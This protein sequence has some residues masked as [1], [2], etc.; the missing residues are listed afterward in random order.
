[1]CLGQELGRFADVLDHL[2]RM[3]R[4]GHPI[5]ERQSGVEVAFDE[6]PAN[7]TRL[8][9][10]DRPAVDIHADGG[11]IARA[12]LVQPSSIPAAEVDDEVPTLEQLARCPLAEVSI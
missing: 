10:V 12:D 6:L 9:R 1:M 5:V 11:P 4:V 2:V 7:R 3:D 8:A